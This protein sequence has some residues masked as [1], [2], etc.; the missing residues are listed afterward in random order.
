MDI[1]DAV[2]RCEQFIFM[3]GWTITAFNYTHRFEDSVLVHVEIIGPNWNAEYAPLYEV[4]AEGYYLG[5][6]P[7]V[8]ALTPEQLER[9]LFEHCMRAFVHEAREAF[10]VKRGEKWVAPFHP[11]TVEGMQRWGDIESDLKHA[12]A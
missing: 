8:G 9:A 12:L 11:H 4:Q 5:V 7:H 2:T 6:I 3:P 10:R 1:N